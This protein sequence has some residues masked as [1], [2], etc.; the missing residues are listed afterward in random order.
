M[1]RTR[2]ASRPRRGIERTNK[3]EHAKGDSCDKIAVRLS[4][5]L[6]DHLSGS[7]GIGIRVPGLEARQSTIRSGSPYEREEDGSDERLTGARLSELLAT[8]RRCFPLRAQ[9]VS[10]GESVLRLGTTASII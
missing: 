9:S 8:Q 7:V 2:D 4:V 6:G 10:A 3:V 1:E 5:L